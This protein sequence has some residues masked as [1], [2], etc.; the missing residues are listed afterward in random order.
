MFANLETQTFSLLG[1]RG[2]VHY[3]YLTQI[4]KSSYLT[5]N[6]FSVTFLTFVLSL[7]VVSL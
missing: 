2:S 6:R 4:H 1:D 7:P 5:D 3:W